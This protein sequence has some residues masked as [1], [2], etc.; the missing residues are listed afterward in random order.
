[1]YTRTHACIDTLSLTH[2]HTHPHILTRFLALPLF[3]SL[4]HTHTHAH[5]YANTETT[6]DSRALLKV[7]EMLWGAEN[8]GEES[9]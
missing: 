6:A 5:M 1:M 3:L 4:F 2:T 8:E 7:R 9:V